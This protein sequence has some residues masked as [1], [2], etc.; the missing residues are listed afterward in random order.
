[1]P[2]IPIL[3][4]LGALL[5]AIGVRGNPLALAGAALLAIGFGLGIVGV[6]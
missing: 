6:A 2:L 4:F 5:L 3:L 1:M